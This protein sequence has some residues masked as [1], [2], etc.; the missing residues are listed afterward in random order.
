[1]DSGLSL[2]L[3]L[4]LYG[5][6]AGLLAWIWRL[7]V[8]QGTDNALLVAQM[9][10]DKEALQEKVNALALKLADGYHNK[11]DLRQVLIE[12]LGPMRD[13]IRQLKEEVRS[14]RNGHVRQHT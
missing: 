10:K 3:I 11:D 4:A 14:Q 13:D 8:K 5:P 6:I 1:M 12:L 7:W 2:G 9:A